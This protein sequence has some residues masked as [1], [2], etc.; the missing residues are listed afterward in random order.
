VFFRLF[1]RAPLL[2]EEAQTKNL[3]NLKRQIKPFPEPSKAAI[4]IMWQ[5][6]LNDYYLENNGKIYS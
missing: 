6:C 2:E 5:K 3:N 1:L 4:L